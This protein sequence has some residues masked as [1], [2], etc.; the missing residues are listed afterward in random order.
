[1]V[2]IY[3]LDK[4]ISD[5]TAYDLYDIILTFAIYFKSDCNSISLFNKENNHEI[6]V[7]VPT[8]NNKNFMKK[9]NKM[10]LYCIITHTDTLVIHASL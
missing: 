3:H 9:I 10:C 2:V 1:M 4:I 8:T 6:T 7:R 5:F